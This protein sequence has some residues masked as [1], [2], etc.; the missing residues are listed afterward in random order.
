MTRAGYITHDLRLAVNFCDAVYEGRKSFE[1]RRNDRGYQTG[2]HIRF[3][4]FRP[5]AKDDDEKYPDHPIM[6]NEYVITY[7]LNG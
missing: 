1:I 5:D 2:D 7:M 3:V 4:P 6:Y